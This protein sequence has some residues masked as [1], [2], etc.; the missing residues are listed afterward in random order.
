MKT[1]TLP[2]NIVGSILRSVS[3]VVLFDISSEIGD[4]ALSKFL[5][6]FLHIG[7]S[8]DI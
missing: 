7:N 1:I 4:D 6:Q 2:F 8:D 3:L 5:A